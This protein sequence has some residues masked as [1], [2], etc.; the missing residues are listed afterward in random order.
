MQRF[1][2]QIDL[3]TVISKM[4][5]QDKDTNYWEEARR[6]VGRTATSRIAWLLSLL[7]ERRSFLSLLERERILLCHE[8]A[9]FFNDHQP[10]SENEMGVLYGQIRRGL[11]RLSRGKPWWRRVRRDYWI[12]L[13]SREAVCIQERNY[14]RRY[15]F[16][17]ILFEA[18][19]GMV[20]YVYGCP[21][22]GR[23]F[24]RTPRQRRYCSRKCAAQMRLRRHRDKKR[25][26]ATA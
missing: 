22:C 9:V 18:I 1:Y 13:D 21:T 4:R 16:G 6:R 23:L 24:P 19:E 25:Q 7:Y 2:N 15:T 11:D 20:G 10:L 3:E 17:R 12:A 14:R 5:T 26:R 8:M